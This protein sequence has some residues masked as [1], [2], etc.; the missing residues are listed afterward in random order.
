MIGMLPVTASEREEFQ[1]MAIEHFSELNPTFVPQD[2]W[3][4]NYFQSILANHQYFLRWMIHGETKAGFI[5]FGLVD[6]RFLNRKTGV[7]F[8]LYVRPQFRRHGIGR[9]CAEEAIRELWTHAPSKIELEVVN[10]H[11]AAVAFWTSMGFQKITERFVLSRGK[12]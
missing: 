8:E 3:K 4:E 7:I 6:H 1:Q 5:L 11:A 10:G 12:S 9:T 2:D